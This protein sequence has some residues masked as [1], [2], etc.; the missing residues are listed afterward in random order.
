M[1]SDYEAE[2]L[3]ARRTIPTDI[4]ELRGAIDALGMRSTQ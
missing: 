2:R 4:E 1:V 3:A